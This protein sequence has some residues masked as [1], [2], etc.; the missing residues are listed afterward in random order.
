[1]KKYINKTNIIMLAIIVIFTIA[2][3]VTLHNSNK[4]IAKRDI[5]IEDYHNKLEK[6]KNTLSPIEELSKKVSES[7]VLIEIILEDINIEKETI[8]RLEANYEANLLKKACYTDQMTRL[9]Q[10]LETINWF[11]EVEDNLNNYRSK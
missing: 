2:N 9:S 11:C 7:S 8:S 5:L 4:E 3:Y 1:M 6:E 10:D